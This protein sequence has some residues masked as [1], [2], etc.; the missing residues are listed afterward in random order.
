MTRHTQLLLPLLSLAALLPSALRA[1]DTPEQLGARLRQAIEGYE[2]L[3]KA[4]DLGRVPVDA[5]DY[6]PVSDN[7][8]EFGERLEAASRLALQIEAMA[9]PDWPRLATALQLLE[10][11]LHQLRCQSL[12]LRVWAFLRKQG[13]KK[14]E[15]GLAVSRSPEPLPQAR[16][17]CDGEAVETLEISLRPGEQQIAQVIVVPLTRDVRRVQGSVGKLKGSAGTLPAQGVSLLPVD[18]DRLTHLQGTE[19]WWRQA[20]AEARPTVPTDVTQAFVLVVAAPADARPG[21]YSGRL[22]FA[23][24][25]LKARELPLKITIP[26]AETPT[27]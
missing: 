7:T 6:R 16:G 15:W 21:A 22:R 27:P 12:P 3:V 11:D 17:A 24:E 19:S 5:P 10:N 13:Q 23:P 26:A 14:P 18:Y 2:K 4:L 9:Q 20:T 1:Q 25:G 8:R